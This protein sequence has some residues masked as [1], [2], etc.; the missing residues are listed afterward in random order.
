MNPLYADKTYQD[1]LQT[2][3]SN[4]TT[5]S[6]R[7]GVGTTSVFGHRME[8]DVSNGQIPLL[9]TKQ[10]HTKSIVHELLWFISGS[11]DNKVLNEKG[12]TIWDEWAK[13]DGSLGKI[14]GYQWRKQDSIK[15]VH[16]NQPA[17]I[18]ELERKGYTA[19]AVDSDFDVVVM[20]KH[21]D[22]LQTAIND[23][24]NNADSRRIIVNAWNASDLDEMQLPPCHALFQFYVN[25]GSLDLQLYQRSADAFLG[26]PFN[27]SQYCILLHMVARITNLKP[28]KFSW[29]GGDCHIYANHYDQVQTLLAR[30]GYESPTLRIIDRGQKEIDD[31]IYEDFV[32]ENYQFHPR[33]S[34]PVAK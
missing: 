24:R 27:I 2:I 17:R 14:Y 1:F 21:I 6:D 18:S 11:T 10:M 7:T 29:V 9:T 15:L 13:E 8:F 20:Q 26:V 23:I 31:F 12:V 22:Q 16:G 28:G 30:E 33:I 25:S 19:A 4:G 5:K 3:L 34:A 32:I